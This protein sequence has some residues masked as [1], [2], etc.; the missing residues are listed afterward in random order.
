M[1]NDFFKFVETY[2]DDIVAFFEALV[3]FVKALF[4]KASSGEDDTTTE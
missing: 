4:D 1:N 3:N 2:W